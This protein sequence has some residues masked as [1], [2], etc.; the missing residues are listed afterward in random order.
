MLYFSHMKN[1]ISFDQQALNYSAK[2]KMEINL[3]SPMKT[4][5]D[6]SLAYT[7]GIAKVCQLI[8]KNE[9]AMF[10]HTF[11]QNALAVISD[12]SAVLGLGN[13]GSKAS[14]PVME[15]K[16]MLFKRFGNID[17]IPV[18]I[19]TQ[20]EKEFIETV[21]NIA[22]SFAAINLEDINAPRCFTIEK[23][24]VKTLDIPVMHDD[25][26]GTGVVVLAALLNALQVLPKDGKSTKIV[27]LGAGAA[28][29]GITMLLTTYGFKNIVIVDSKGIISKK[30][31]DLH[32][33]KK[34]LLK[35]TNPDNLSGSLQDA[36]KDAD[37][38]IGVSR[39]EL[40]EK[41]IKL[42]NPEPIIF[43]MANPTPEIMPDK[44]LK[45]GAGIVGTGRS[46]FPNQINNALVFPG[47]FRGAMDARYKITDAMKLAAAQAV[48]EYHKKDLSAD[49]I[50]PSILDEKVHAFIAKRVKEA[51]KK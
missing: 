44:A 17:A 46:D 5:T 27:V 21:K 50:L 30:R 41:D 6:L 37:V 43:A 28:G 32:A 16:A 33:E 36:L 51:S 23:E 24:L 13:I 19:K 39:G 40:T 7:P 34:T 29:M 2:P 8:Q 20:D 18:V 42:M 15:G 26:H 31:T 48:V 10:T 1:T 38:F 12:G 14:Y 22:D 45:A 25:Q 9:D 47:I 35:L 3:L 4:R 49:T 11:R